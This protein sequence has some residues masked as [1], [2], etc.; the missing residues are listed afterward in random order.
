M[1][2]TSKHLGAKIA[3]TITGPTHEE[4]RRPYQKP[5]SEYAREHE[6]QQRAAVFSIE[7]K[8]S[9]GKVQTHG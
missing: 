5:L 7:E 8:S 1:S 3:N 6:Q 9:K 4:L 2:D